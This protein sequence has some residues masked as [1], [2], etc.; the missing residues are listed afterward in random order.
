MKEQ[1]PATETLS[2]WWRRSVVMVF[3]CGM[4]VLVFMSVQAYRYAH[5]YARLFGRQKYRIRRHAFRPVRW[6]LLAI[7]RAP[8]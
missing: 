5:Y 4:A 8:A 3:V 6:K 1:L 2:E 7:L